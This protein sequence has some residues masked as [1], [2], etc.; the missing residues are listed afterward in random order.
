VTLWSGTLGL[1]QVFHWNS[2]VFQRVSTLTV[3]DHD[4][5]VCAV[6]SGRCT[7]S[8]SARV[9]THQLRGTKSME[10]C[11]KT[12]FTGHNFFSFAQLGRL[13][14][15][16]AAVSHPRQKHSRPLKS[17]SYALTGTFSRCNAVA[18]PGAA[19]VSNLSTA[20]LARCVSAWLSPGNCWYIFNIA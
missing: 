14:N 1:A 8:W 16:F 5:H 2:R 18:S 9:A 11:A 4:E 12:F 17:R 6:T 20:A 10:R 7:T 15:R 19:A 3:V 13:T